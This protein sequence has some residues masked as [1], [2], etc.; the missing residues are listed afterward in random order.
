MSDI[1]ARINA[2]SGGLPPAPRQALWEGMNT[3]LDLSRPCLLAG[4][5]ASGKSGLALE[6]AESSGALIVNADALQVY[7][8]WQVL[9][10]RPSDADCARADHVLYGSVG[11]DRVHS[12]GAWLDDMAAVLAA[13]PGRPVILVGGTGLYFTA[14]T[15]GLATIPAVPTEVRAAHDRLVAEGGFAAVVAELQRDDP[16]TA[17]RIRLDN[18]RRVQRAWEVLR[19]TGRGLSA[20]QGDPTAPLL[21]RA[22]C[23]A[24]LLSPDRDVLAG[25]IARR[26]DAM[27][28]A[29]ALDE[30]AA[31]LPHWDDTLPAYRAIGAA[32]LRDHLLGRL[33]REAAVERAVIATRQY[34]KRQRSWFRARMKDWHNISTV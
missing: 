26:F 3:P 2:K 28:D 5:T 8:G 6:A 27:L 1:P 4:P 12:V 33:S 25:R 10:A 20:W 23:N 21:P 18:P 34:A 30:V 14:L 31:N 32:E 22:S 17:A 15:E 7:D 13:N 9:T 11:M 16:V 19:A 29:G 24:Y